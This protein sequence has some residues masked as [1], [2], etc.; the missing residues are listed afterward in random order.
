M[1]TTSSLIHNT[2]IIILT[3]QMI[4]MIKAT[5][6]IYLIPAIIKDNMIRYRQPPRQQLGQRWSRRRRW[7]ERHQTD[8]TRTCRGGVWCGGGA[9]EGGGGGEDDDV[10]IIIICTLMYSLK[11]PISPQVPHFLAPSLHWLV[12]KTKRWLVNHMRATKF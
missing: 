10:V 7:L 5:T 2:I 1:I 8:C 6:Y 3:D 9:E 11:K 4:T 12:T